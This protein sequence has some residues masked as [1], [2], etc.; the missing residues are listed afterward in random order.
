MNNSAFTFDTLAPD[1]YLIISEF[2][3]IY[4]LSALAL[5]NTKYQQ[6]FQPLIKNPIMRV[7][8]SSI[9]YLI[10][11]RYEIFNIN[12]FMHELN[13][14]GLH[15]RSEILYT[16]L[17]PYDKS[18]IKRMFYKLIKKRYNVSLDK[19]AFIGFRCIIYLYLYLLGKYPS[20]PQSLNYNNDKLNYFADDI[21][22]MIDTL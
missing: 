1:V 6:I 7:L 13:V 21:K 12:V 22:Y 5:V 4:M 9:S 8:K 3:D 18:I 11:I 19:H 17:H 10:K 2:C 15:S 14:G 16:Y 20:N